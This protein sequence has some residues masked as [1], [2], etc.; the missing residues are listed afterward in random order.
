MRVCRS[1]EMCLDRLQ[2][3]QLYNLVLAGLIGLAAKHLRHFSPDPHLL[4]AVDEPHNLIEDRDQIIQ[5]STIPS[6]YEHCEMLSG[7]SGMVYFKFS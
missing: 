2:L 3:P 1:S 4:C 6:L 5:V 7:L